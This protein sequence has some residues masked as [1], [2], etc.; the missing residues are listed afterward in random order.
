ML[1]IIHATWGYKGVFKDVSGILKAKINL[2]GDLIIAVNTATLTDPCNGWVK[3]LNVIYEYE[4]KRHH[5]LVQ[6][7]HPQPYGARQLS[8]VNGIATTNTK[9]PGLIKIAGLV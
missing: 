2:A 7:Q 4:G 9:Y 6:E 1:T 8:I 3:E 5:I